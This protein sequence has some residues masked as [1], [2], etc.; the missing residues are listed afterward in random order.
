MNPN[1]AIPS[2]FHRRLVL[3][4]VMGAV[5]MLG[6]SAQLAR[7]AVVEGDRRLSEAEGRLRQETYLAVPRA[8]I[9][10]RQGVVLARDTP[11]YDI[12]VEY[13]V[14]SG[15]SSVQQAT[16]DARKELGRQVWDEMSPEARAAELG[17]R[18]NA[19]DR[20]IEMLWQQIMLLG[21]MTRDELDAR[22]DLIRR[23]VQRRAEYVWTSRAEAMMEAK[24]ARTW[25]EATAASRQPIREQKQPHVILPRVP[26]AVA[27]E[28]RYL[29]AQW[30]DMLEVQDST[31]REYPESMRRVT[32][33]RATLPRP[34][35]SDLPLDVTVI[36]VADHTLGLMRDVWAED[37]RRRPSVDS[38]TGRI[39]LKGYR[40]DDVVGARGLEQ[41]FEDQLRGTRGVVRR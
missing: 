4:T 28:F 21:N 34:I 36:G 15:I 40:Q 22:L 14:I 32:L 17:P 18:I 35:R 33:N 16:R 23:T 37:I 8:N 39:D 27:F 7:L 31:R 12:A 11:S 20:Q 29:Q 2:M 1:K 6:L 38:S 3:L 13:E 24:H 19:Y 5:T 25:A 10:D 41:R 9:L 30:P 26:D